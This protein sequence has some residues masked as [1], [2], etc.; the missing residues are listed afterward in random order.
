MNYIIQNENGCLDNNLHEIS[1]EQLKILYD[2]NI[3]EER[4]SRE[5]TRSSY[6][7]EN[8]YTQ[9]GNLSEEFEK[10]VLFRDSKTAGM[11][12]YYPHGVVIQQAARRNYYRGENQIFKES[13]PSLLRALKKYPTPK[14]KELYRF[15]ADMRI[16]EFKFLLE[17]FEHVINWN[18]CDILYEPLAQHYGLETGWI[19]ITS[20]FN[21]ALFFATCY[22]DN[23]EG[24]WKP[25]TKEQTE[26][27]ENHKYGVI[28]HMPSYQMPERWDCA[29]EQFSIFKYKRDENGKDTFVRKDITECKGKT[30]NLIYPIGFQP[31]MR[32]HM[33]NAYGIYMRED[34]PLQS[35]LQFEKLKFRHNEQFSQKV[36]DLMKGGELIYPHEGLRQADFI[37]NQIKNA[38]CFSE[39]AFQYALY[40]NH[41]FSIKDADIAKNEL[42]SFTVNGHPIEITDRHPWKMSS[43]RRQK[44][45]R[46]YRDFS[47]QAYYGIII[48]DRLANY[49]KMF[50]PWM[51]PE[52]ADGEGIKDFYV[53]EEVKQGFSIQAKSW[54][55]LLST[56][57]KGQQSDF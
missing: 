8:F 5:I 40:R 32:C 57:R 26:V 39:E 30:E 1:Q 52:E 18:I 41:W 11:R 6:E 37:I 33:Q 56:I 35:D 3:C 21:V 20:D 15:V 7:G 45:N 14:E 51:L 49:S 24:K 42:Q 43:G 34:N 31:F 38:Y 36:F 4:E 48:L 47:V 2:D 55:S 53:S 9:G 44:I 13:V 50:E 54:I 10:E 23:T 25:L 12:I 17:R 16:A 22:W 46:L 29:L 27:D 28:F 19:D